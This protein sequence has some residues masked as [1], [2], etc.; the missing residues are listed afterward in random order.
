M[1]DLRNWFLPVR[2]YTTGREQEPEL[3]V[4]SIRAT[5]L[6]GPIL[7]LKRDDSP[8]WV[9]TV[10]ITDIESESNDAIWWAP[11]VVMSAEKFDPGMWG[12]NQHDPRPQQQGSDAE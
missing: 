3:T 4:W 11:I 1:T 12:W 8:M 6:D 9:R 5:S 7:C 2:T 10:F